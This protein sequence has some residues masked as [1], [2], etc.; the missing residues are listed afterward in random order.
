VCCSPLC[1]M[2]TL[3]LPAQAVQECTSDTT[4]ALLRGGGA[5]IAGAG[6]LVH[7]C[8]QCI[9]DLMMAIAV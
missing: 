7:P 6:A 1:F 9:S 4:T 3:L 5:D 8:M 2:T